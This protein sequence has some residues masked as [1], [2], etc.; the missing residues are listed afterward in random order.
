MNHPIPLTTDDAYHLHTI[1]DNQTTIQGLET[2][3]AII[4]TVILLSN[5]STFMYLENIF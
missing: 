2:G 1:S 3:K 4:F 5:N